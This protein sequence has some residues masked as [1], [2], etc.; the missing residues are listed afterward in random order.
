MKCRFDGLLLTEEFVN[1]GFS[2]PSN[3]FLLEKQLNEAETY[4]PLKLFVSERSFLVQLDE[5]KRAEEIFSDDY[6]YFSSFSTTWL[7]HSKKYVEKMISKFGF[8]ENAQIIEIASNDGYL[9]QYFKQK[10]IPVLGIEP[11]LSTAKVAREKGIESWT[12]FFGVELAKK[13][14][15]QGRKADLL[16][17]N[18]VLAHVPDINDFVAGMKVALKENG[19]I[20]MEFPH[21][22]QLIENNQFDTIYH[23]HFSYLSFLAVQQIFDK[24][25]L[26]L[27]DVEEIPTH[28]GSLRIYAKHSEDNSKEISE[29]VTLLQQKE[30]NKGLNTL[31]YYQ[32]FQKRVENIKYDFLSFLIEQK[33]NGKKVAAYG[34]AA[35]GNT[36]L[37]YCGIRKDMISFVVDK[38][39]HKQGRFLPGS[40]I[41]VVSEDF[42]S[43]ER[44]DF[45]VI[46]PWN[47]KEEI[48]EQLNYV[49]AWGTKFVTAIPELCI[50]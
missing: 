41:P 36:L 9:L 3:S 33:R 40:H 27:F 16:L 29:N 49:R 42:I 34:A 21:L 23:E 5:F 14:I 28:G 24:H 26:S 4:Y 1:L 30:I 12:E 37:N 43:R 39:P 50:F 19:V 8:N 11:T 15:E 38:S 20:T 22:M 31:A 44:P 48:Q 10:N 45:V 13:I 47:I 46:L 35:K 6:V 7:E 18:N 25:G 2:P 32:N 17:G